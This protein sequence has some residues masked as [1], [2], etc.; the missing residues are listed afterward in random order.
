[1]TSSAKYVL[2]SSPQVRNI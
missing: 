2:V 1:M